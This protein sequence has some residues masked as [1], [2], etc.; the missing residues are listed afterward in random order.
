MVELNVQDRKIQFVSYSNRSHLKTN[1]LIPLNKLEIDT[2]GKITK[3][4]FNGEYKSGT[5]YLQTICQ[6]CENNL[7]STTTTRLIREIKYGDQKLTFICRSCSAKK[8]A[9]KVD[10]EKRNKI[11]EENWKK[12]TEKEKKEFREAIS[13]GRLKYANITEEKILRAINAYTENKEPLSVIR[14]ILGVAG[15]HTAQK[16]LEKNGI[17]TRGFSEARSI[18]FQKNPSKNP[19]ARKDVIEKIREYRKENPIIRDGKPSKEEKEFFDKLQI[20]NK[21]QHKRIKNKQFDILLNDSIYIEFDGVYWHGKDGESYDL[22]QIYTMLNDEEKNQIVMD[23]EKTLYR[24][25]SDTI[26]NKYNLNELREKAYYIIE[27]GNLIKDDREF[28]SVIITHE[29]I[30]N[31]KNR[32]SDKFESNIDL[33]TT[34]VQTFYDFPFINNNESLND[35]VGKIRKPL[36]KL[37]SINRTGNDFLK[38]RFQSFYYAKRN[39]KKSMYDAY[40][41]F[42]ELKKI[43]QNRLGI[44]YKEKW[45]LTPETIR[46]G[47]ISNYYSV[48]FFN[49]KNAYHIFNKIAKP[50][51]TVLDMSAGF[52]GRLLGWYAFQDG[53]KYIGYEPNKMTYN[54]LLNFSKEL[55]ANIEIYNKPFEKSNPQKVDVCFSCPPYFD[56][57]IYSNEETQSIYKYKTYEEWLD[58]FLFKSIENMKNISNRVY[59]VV[60]KRLYDSIGG[61]II[62]TVVNKQSHF[63]GKDNFEYLIRL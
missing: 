36:N 38:T 42:E 41:D 62:D 21:K 50:S 19:F 37:N 55:D 44:T 24:I 14:D 15:K 56:I 20:Q 1:N 25:W 13:E 2:S 53:G 27:N 61:T 7:F 17:E 33:L 3:W 8:N 30:H 47:F 59:L 18:Y 54:E 4:Y 49:P 5:H 60:D 63:T 43:I 31:N 16:I 58:K 46:R 52:G 34:F 48:S 29:Y 26:F 45:N 9:D 22:P 40:Y 51:D 28:K 12:K 57:E 11:R 32:H 39:R 6:E 35:I 23:E 10:I